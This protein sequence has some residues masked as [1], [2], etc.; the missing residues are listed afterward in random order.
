MK[1]LHQKVF[2][3]LRSIPTLYYPPSILFE[4][5]SGPQVEF[6]V[7]QCNDYICH[8]Q[9]LYFLAVLNIVDLFWIDVKEMNE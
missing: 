6:Y 5:I 3:M 7:K 4:V 2:V 1:V 8:Y 9:C